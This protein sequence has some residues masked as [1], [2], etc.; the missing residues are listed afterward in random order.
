M[1]DNV[2][3]RLLKNCGYILFGVVLGIL[4]TGTIFSPNSVIKKYERDREKFETLMDSIEQNRMVS[5]GDFDQLIEP[6]GYKIYLEINCSN[7][8]VI[9]L[10]E[11]E[12]YALEEGDFVDYTISRL[13]EEIYS[14]RRFILKDRDEMYLLKEKAEPII[15]E[16]IMELKENKVI[17]MHDY[18]EW[19]KKLIKDTE[20]GTRII[21]SDDLDK[22]IKDNVFSINGEDATVMIYHF[23][24]NVVAI[25]LKNY[26]VEF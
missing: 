19:N 4:I 13:G 17:D 16:Y 14:G 23:T 5:M 26:E 7:D 2:F 24:P 21:F 20:I 15:D 8:K 10:D 22:E 9:S 1:I 3:K 25:E 18:E 6:L 12:N 11:I